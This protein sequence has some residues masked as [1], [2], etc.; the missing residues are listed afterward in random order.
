MYPVEAGR[1]D[2]SLPDVDW[3]PMSPAPGNPASTERGLFVGLTVLDL[4][5]AVPGPVGPNQ[6]VRAT[7]Q[8]LAAGGPATNAAVTFAAL[9]GTATLLTALG[10]HPLTDVVRADLQSQ[11]VGLVDASPDEA[12]AP[13]VA[14]IAV[15]PEGGR[16]VVSAYGRRDPPEPLGLA[17]LVAGCG[18]VLLDGHHPRLALAAARAARAAGVPVLLDA[19]SWKPRTAELLPLVD[20]VIASADFAPPEAK[21][22]DVLGL[23]HRAGVPAAAITA[24]PRQVRWSVQDGPRGEIAPPKV[25]AVDTLGAGD[26]FHGAAAWALAGLVARAPL[27]QVLTTRLPEL[28]E[29]AC[30]IAARRVQVRGAGAWRDVLS[31]E[32]SVAKP[33]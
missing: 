11:R 6:K 10:R 29:Y 14:A 19:G 7:G 27:A 15:E 18:V 13:T 3:A 1:I 25:K 17:E 31:S 28:L 20:L 33:A 32:R 22:G 9:G 5:L 24:G 23:L 26:V 21:D 2:R 8:E 30:A 12:E 4:V 16:Q